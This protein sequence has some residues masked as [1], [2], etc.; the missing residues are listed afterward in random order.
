MIIGNQQILAQLLTIQW[1]DLKTK[2]SRPRPNLTSHPSH[3]NHRFFDSPG[4]GGIRTP[5]TPSPDGT[6]TGGEYLEIGKED[7][8]QYAHYGYVYCMAL[9]CGLSS[10][11]PDGEI[12]IS[13]GGDGTIKL[14]NLNRDNGGAIKEI[15]TLENGDNSVLTVALDGMFLYSGLLE[16]D[17]NVWD[18]DT[19]QLVRSVKAHAEDELTLTIG[20][21]FIFSGGAGCSAKV[22]TNTKLL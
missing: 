19:R 17:I 18:L 8:V 20:G 22:S 11:E 16:G 4:P 5:R 6:V 15:A 9:C 2:D 14:W 12:L 1:Y 10:D 7:I 21:G 13:G 3:R